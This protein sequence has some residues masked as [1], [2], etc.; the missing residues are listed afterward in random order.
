MYAYP[1]DLT[2]PPLAP[3]FPSQY[4]FAAHIAS[5][6]ERE[7]FDAFFLTLI[8]KSAHHPFF[9]TCHLKRSLSVFFSETIASNWYRDR[10]INSFFV[11]AFLD[12]PGSRTGFFAHPCSGFDAVQDS[13]HHHCIILT[14]PEITN[15][16]LKR[17]WFDPVDW[18]CDLDLRNRTPVRSARLQ[19]V[20][21]LEDLKRVA[22][23]CAKSIQKF[24]RSYPD[25][26]YFIL[27]DPPPLHSLEDA[28][29]S[30][31]HSM[32]CIHRKDTRQMNEECGAHG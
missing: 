14:K 26:C 29:S 30:S 12:E 32:G 11:Y 21:T 15:K 23:Y 22:S 6:A 25:D 28:T 24:L 27:P 2:T 13:Y 18:S 16:I 10:Y 17:V 8:Y 1:T 4:D 7:G 31:R 3:S 9:A 5:H 20:P 19:T